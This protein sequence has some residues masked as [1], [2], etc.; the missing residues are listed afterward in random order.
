[1]RWFRVECLEKR[2]SN[3]LASVVIVE[4]RVVTIDR[5]NEEY[6]S[7]EMKGPPCVSLDKALV[8][9]ACEMN[10]ESVWYALFGRAKRERHRL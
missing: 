5:G 3:S 9:A 2:V 7:G 8:G 10:V 4:G 6:L 1:M